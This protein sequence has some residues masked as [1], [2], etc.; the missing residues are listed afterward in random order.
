M[1]ANEDIQGTCGSGRS[2]PAT[3]PSSR[4]PPCVE[5]R[6]TVLK[7]KAGGGGGSG[8]GGARSSLAPMA[9]TLAHRGLTQEKAG[10]ALRV[11]GC[12]FLFFSHQDPLSP[13][14]V[15]DIQCVPGP[16]LKVFQIII[17]SDPHIRRR[18]FST[19]PRQKAACPGHRQGCGQ[20]VALRWAM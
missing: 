12:R 13:F 9:A 16:E 15:P 6:S 3:H 11:I 5:Q 20:A 17:P 8:G 4:K 2:Q 14:T 7:G 1:W 18:C 10:A 19:F